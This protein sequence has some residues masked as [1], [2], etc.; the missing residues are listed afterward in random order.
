MLLLTSG[1]EV[2]EMARCRQL[3]VS[4]CLTKPVSRERLYDAVQ[5][6]LLC[7]HFPPPGA[8]QESEVPCPQAAVALHKD[9]P[10]ILLAEDSPVN[11]TLVMTVL[12]KRGYRMTLVENGQQAVE[13]AQ[14]GH[15]DCVLMDVQATRLIRAHEAG[16]GRGRVPIIALTANAIGGDA[17]KCLEAGMDFYLSK[18]VN[19]MRLLEV[20]EKFIQQAPAESEV[21]P[22]PEE[23]ATGQVDVASLMA[24][25]EGDVELAVDLARM[26][27]AELDERL[28]SVVAAAEARDAE[29]LEEVAHALK[30]MIAVF[31]KG[32]AF[33]AVRDLNV[34]AKAG[35]F[36]QSGFL[37]QR[38]RAG[39][40]V[41]RQDLE[42]QLQQWQV[43][44]GE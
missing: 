38:L 16:T 2:D 37:C 3:G 10:S 4:S 43:P 35:D 25:T 22:Q 30:G 41:L 26:F 36:S 42:S 13:A 8:V 28:A 12:Q 21:P 34:A 6:A 33:E 19:S 7:P 44:H 40:A 15:F 29:R 18:P 17:E 39:T 27:L 31:S 9:S 23:A 32:H 20:V 24:Q 5:N 11:Q 14:S 1:G